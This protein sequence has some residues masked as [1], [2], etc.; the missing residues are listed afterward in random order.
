M[1]VL[2][3]ERER[4]PRDKVCGDC[5]NPSA[6]EVLG[7]LGIDERI[8][9][10]PHA[11][12]KKLQIV[13]LNQRVFEFPLHAGA[14]A[15]IG[16][17]R[18]DLDLA[19]MQ[20][21]RAAGAAFL[22]NTAVTSIEGEWR[23]EAGGKQFSCKT[24]VAAD[25]R[26]SSVARLLGLLPPQ[27]K[28]RVGIQA[29]F[30]LA[31]ENRNSVRM[32]LHPEGYSGGASIGDDLWNLCLVARGTQIDSL[33]ARASRLWNLPSDVRW[34]SLTPLS[35]APLA[36]AQGS[37]LLVGDAARVV[38]PFTGEGIY[39]ALASGE[40]AGQHLSEPAVY[41]RKH[42][43]LYRGRLW[44]NQLARAAVLHPATT[45]WLLENLPAEQLLRHLTTKVTSGPPGEPCADNRTATKP[46][47]MP[48]TKPPT[49]PP[50]G[51]ALPRVYQPV[52]PSVRRSF[53]DDPHHDEA[54][55]FPPQSDVRKP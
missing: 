41:G 32:Q 54:P 13:T 18:R 27:Q 8:R 39:Y 47:M 52:S 42:R 2:V 21:A 6:W 28:D 16:L 36:P 1:R 33:K 25:G 19:L 53:Y 30:P 20:T 51:R 31:R 3:I 38:E 50:S 22:E 17:R 14:T 44:V 49:K 7:R 37:L 24:L 12:L 11:P 55:T 46:P 40:L 26:N 43:E 23:I 29:H 48:P 15:E 9:S 45:S 35:R 10:L 34:R 5:L 4:F